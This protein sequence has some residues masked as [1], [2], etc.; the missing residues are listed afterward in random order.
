MT[1]PGEPIP[2]AD[3]SG[4]PGVSRVL[5]ALELHRIRTTVRFLPDAVRTAAAAADALGVTPGEIANSLVFATRTHDRR[6]RPLLVLAS[7]D[8]RVDV[9]KVAD[10]AELAA[11]ERANP[12]Q[13]R[14]WTGFA[15]GGVAPVGHPR[16]IRTLVDVTLGRHDTVW[17][18]AGHSHSVFAT[19]YDELLRLTGGQPMEVA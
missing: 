18:A 12:D 9:D 19:T 4:H 16:P 14:D 10:L 8:H 7:G 3:L 13:V 1:H 11:V 2:A 15:I 5:D 17:A 6:T